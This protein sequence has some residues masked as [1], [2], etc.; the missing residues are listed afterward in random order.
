MCIAQYCYGKL[1]FL[2]LENTE[3]LPQ[4]KN[5]PLQ[6]EKGEIMI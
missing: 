5:A 2:T 4:L 3:V 1:G 6:G